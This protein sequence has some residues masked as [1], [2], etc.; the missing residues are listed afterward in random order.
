[1]YLQVNI[2]YKVA[3]SV[4]LTGSLTLIFKISWNYW[5]CWY[6]CFCVFFTILS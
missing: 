5:S 6:L 4:I 2:N 3:V 1:M